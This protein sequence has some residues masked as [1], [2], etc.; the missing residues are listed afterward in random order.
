MNQI[1]EFKNYYL[2]RLKE[3]ESEIFFEEKDKEN[4]EEIENK[5]INNEVKNQNIE[6]I[7]KKIESTSKRLR[8]LPKRYKIYT[9]DFKKHILEI[10]NKLY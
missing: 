4:C 6:I 5:E 7:L 3:E 2:P 9:L 1:E 10:V 8:S